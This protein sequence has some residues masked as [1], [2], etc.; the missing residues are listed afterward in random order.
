MNDRFIDCMFHLDF[1]R[2]EILETSVDGKSVFVFYSDPQEAE[3]MQKYFYTYEQAA[4]YLY[5]YGY[6]F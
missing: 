3:T 2:A 1:G 6:R 5:R 4:D